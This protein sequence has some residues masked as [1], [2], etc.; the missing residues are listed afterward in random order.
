[1][2]LLLSILTPNIVAAIPLQDYDGSSHPMLRSSMPQFLNMHRRDVISG[3]VAMNLSNLASCDPATMTGYN[4][5]IEDVPGNGP[6]RLAAINHGVTSFWDSVHTGAKDAADITGVSLS[7]FTPENEIFDGDYMVSQILNASRSGFDGIVVTIPNSEI[8]SA[9]M[10]VQREHPGLPMVVMNVGQQSA[11]QQGMLAVLQ[12]ELTAGEMIGNALLD[13]G[14]HDFICLSA[15]RLIQSLADRCSGVLKAF[16]DRGV[17][18]PT[19]AA[20]N[21]TLVIG[22]TDIDSPT[23]YQAITDYLAAHPVVDT[24]IALNT[25]T[26]NQALQVSMNRTSVAAPG[27]VGGLWIGAFDVN[28]VVVESIKSGA[29][30]AAITQSPYLQGAIPVLELFLQISTKQKISQDTFYTGPSLINTNNVMAEYALDQSTSLHDFI[31]QRKSAIV[32]NRDIP[33]EN[34]RWNEAL[35]G[36]VEA[37]ALFGWDTYSATSMTELQN[38]QNN[39]L[40]APQN[41]ASASPG[42]LYGPYKGAQGVV[43]SL[44]DKVQFEDLLN[45]T[46]LP[47]SV[48]IMG[49]GSSANWTAMPSR[50]VFFGPSD[51][52]IGSVFASQMLSS[53]YGVPLC[54]IEDNGPWWQLDHCTQ[55]YNFLVQIYGVA[56]VGRLED[57]VLSVPANATDVAFNVKD[58]SPSGLRQ[59]TSLAA[60]IPTPANNPILQKFSANSTLA[61]DSILCTSLPLYNLVDQLQQYLKK[62]RAG[63]FSA[64][65]LSPF[66]ANTSL[67]TNRPSFSKA[68]PDPT[69]PGVFV[70]GVSPKALYSMAHNQQVTGL[71]DPQQYIQGFHAIISLSVRMM[72]PN[73]TNAFNQL[74]STGPVSVNHVCEAGQYY[75]STWGSSAASAKNGN[76]GS[77]L[78]STVSTISDTSPLASS[79][80]MLCLDAS[81]QVRMQ[82]MCTRCL[83]GQYSN[84][85][86]A[87]QCTSCPSG[88][89][90]DGSGQS[91]C[92]TCNGSICRTSSKLPAILMGVLI[93]L[94]VILAAVAILGFCWQ[95]R[96]RSI[97]ARKL[98][99]DSWQL[100][101]SKLLNSGIGGEPANLFDNASDTPHM[102]GF[103][104]GPGDAVLPAIKV[105]GAVPASYP[106]QKTFSTDFEPR[107]SN[108]RAGVVGD[109]TESKSGSSRI[110]SEQMNS[111]RSGSSV[112]KS[113]P[114]HSGGQFTFIMSRG[115]SARGTWRSMPVYIKKIGSR[116]VVVDS[117]LRK[118]V[119]NMRELRHP[120][121]VEFIGV[122]LAQ[123]NICIVTEFV[124]KGTLASVLANTDHKFTWLFKFSF[125]QDLCR[126][127]EFL[128][129]SKIG[130]HGRLT[131][132]NCLISSR[133]ELKIAGY[134]L[135]GLYKSQMDAALPQININ[136][137][138]PKQKISPRNWLSSGTPSSVS[139]G[140]PLPQ[141]QHQHHGYQLQPEQGMFDLSLEPHRRSRDMR[142]LVESRDTEL[143]SSFTDEKSLNDDDIG[144]S[145]TIP[146]FSGGSRTRTSNSSHHSSS[147]PNVNVYNTSGISDGL[148][149]SGFDHPNDLMPLL[150]VAP[151][152][153]HT[154]KDGEYEA[155]CSQRGDIYSAGIIFNEIL[156]RRL[157]YHDRTDMVSTL[158][159]VQDE[160]LRPDLVNPEG[161]SYSAED[162]DNIEQMNQLIRLCIAKEPSTRPHFT[163]MLA[164]INDINPHKSS[165]FISSMAAMLEKYGNDMEELVRDR[166]RNLQMRTVEL[167]EERGRTNRLLVDLQKAK[168]GAEAAATAKS[169]FLAN[170]SHEIRTP[171]NAVI[172]MS[173]ILLDSKLNP[174]LA[175]CAETI[176]SSGNQLMTVIDDILDFSKIESGNLKL[177]RRLL[178]LSFVIESAVNLI[179]SQATAKNLSL[180]YE[181]DTKCPVEIMGDVTRIRQILLNLMSNAVKFTQHGSI[182]VSV[183]IEPQVEVKFED[184]QAVKADPMRLMPPSTTTTT[185]TTIFKK[186]ESTIDSSKPQSLNLPRSPVPSPPTSPQSIDSPTMSDT[187]AD[188]FRTSSGSLVPPMTKP[189]RL[190]FAVKDTGVGIPSDRFDKLFTSFSQ[191]DESTTR[192]YG[193]TGL[194]LAISKRLSE[195]MGGSM[196]VDST[197][198]SGS[199][200]YF[201]IVLDS[202]VGCQSYEEQFDLSRLAEKKLVIVDDSQ[203][204]RDAWKKRTESWK[205]NQ[206]T[207][208]RSDQVLQYF[209]EDSPTTTGAPHHQRFQDK[210]DALIVETDLSDSLCDQP[211]GLLDIIRSAAARSANGVMESDSQEEEDASPAIPVIIFKNM[212]D[213]KTVPST[214]TSYHGHAR[215]DASRWSGER[216]SSSDTGDENRISRRARTTS[217]DECANVLENIYNQ[218][219]DSSTSSLALDRTAS[220]TSASD[221][222]CDIRRPAS[223]STY[224]TGAGNLL[225]PHTQATFYE[226]GSI[227]SI[228]HLSTTA[229]SPAPSLNM[230]SYFSSSDNESTTTPTTLQE[231]MLVQGP[232]RRK[233]LFAVPV[234]FTK[235][236]RHSKVLQMLT[237]DP[238][239][240]EF[241][242]EEVL[243]TNHPNHSNCNGGDNRRH[244]MSG[245]TLFGSAVRKQ[246]TTISLLP[247]AHVN[248]R[249]EKNGKHGHGDGP[250]PL[251]V[252][253]ALTTTTATAAAAEAE[254]RDGFADTPLK[255]Q[256]TAEFKVARSRT[257]SSGSGSEMQQQQPQPEPRSRTVGSIETPSTKK[258]YGLGT[259]KR[260]ASSVTGTPNSSGGGSGG[261]FSSP[262]MAAVAAAS[263]S[264]ARKLA[265][266]KVLVVDDNPV[267]L[268]V[269][270]KM[271]ARLGVEPDTAMNGQEAVELIEKKAA[272]LQLQDEGDGGLNATLSARKMSDAS[273]LSESSNGVGSDIGTSLA[274]SESGSDSTVAT[275]TTTTVKHSGGM[276]T[277]NEDGAGDNTSTNGTGSK[278]QQKHH[279]PYD[280]I[281]LDIW[282]PKMNG[283]D[284][285]MYIRKHLSGDTPNRPYIIAMTACVMPGDREKCIASGMNDYI[286]KPLR[287]EELEQCLRAFTTQHLR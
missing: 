81:G 88:Y 118:E 23:N 74:F 59:D 280:L 147:T 169:N 272:L 128:H 127:M 45:S 212:R 64:T 107:S 167:E 262:S 25:L 156:T 199:T 236:I 65:V 50:A 49:V 171:M 90:T 260:R 3:A 19:T 166:T 152:C 2:V 148:E 164:R 55:L 257:A 82:S 281:F 18:A 60:D 43:V 77:L 40:A 36:L 180:V 136:E 287:K 119:F 150:W 39:L 179:S 117:E 267:N 115:S 244:S 61:F 12:D 138:Q 89:G 122:C 189:V 284:A 214:S 108:D 278:Q 184:E 154:D 72:Y 266:V 153:L 35:G 200:F 123:P 4:G 11:K 158:H 5:R 130:F 27:R 198:D 135:D 102:S 146:L 194:G 219:P 264:T 85:T 240:M 42:Q 62:T 268:K 137:K 33:L 196:W 205:M 16:I 250:G 26:V 120:K 249:L 38:L 202:P 21:K 9:V 226:Q 161:S 271:L 183:Q 215:R 173:R 29:I 139:D 57:M 129:M 248:H 84:G 22:P 15:N 141:Q 247:P 276:D 192:E 232:C 134:G 58:L 76:S 261:G 172:G 269:I 231:S 17:V 274:G 109:G 83:A 191:V 243:P 275:I 227:S 254:T 10:H 112:S 185:T 209:R 218:H 133:W 73:R 211:E 207:I 239:E 230:T 37:A 233:G 165:D 125:M 6:I 193:G 101:L 105:G 175:E 140:Q 251:S 238:S 253:L 155:H 176:E 31:Q 149:H 213:I 270:S 92:Q 68:A 282:M 1:M 126:G 273:H 95:R 157:P 121:L 104:G 285:S 208:L 8:A 203:M 98:N 114:T 206:A 94:I 132:L 246:P 259:P 54:L 44:A 116:K 252:P 66:P 79:N 174:E 13:K 181:I 41:T 223:A 277:I 162:R 93:P 195:M 51:D 265:K 142:S 53:G 235:P 75:S 113:V 186:R 56:K 47:S 190:L 178:D 110:D 286:S 52:Q 151:E 263:S 48:P 234:Y 78:T 32:L 229:P 100:D 241:E 279:V 80:T 170:M 144:N 124:P 28:D 69:A 163:A 188:T 177:E 222:L 34:T 46:I 20:Y 228:D 103:N 131:S 182:H 67:Q 91:E 106:L 237:E 221:K 224:T 255:S 201:N 14:A 245:L 220:F 187:L 143:R 87:T 99:D 30:V 111:A 258:A 197:V 256:N 24:I 210:M 204:G 168:E 70:L 216:I 97:N 159:R 71:Y 225:T 63:I 86:D 7:W 96:K 283:L 145:S 217:P 160:D 242:V